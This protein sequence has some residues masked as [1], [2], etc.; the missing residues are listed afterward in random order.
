MSKIS[1]VKFAPAALVRVLVE[2]S[3][4]TISVLRISSM[5]ANRCNKICDMC[6]KAYHSNHMNTLEAPNRQWTCGTQGSTVL[7]LTK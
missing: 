1:Y 7:V 5:P 4:L 2:R 6:P 3:A